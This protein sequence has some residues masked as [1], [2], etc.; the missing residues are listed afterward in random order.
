MKGAPMNSDTL[1]I[2]ENTVGTVSNHQVGVSNI[3]ARDLA[4]ETGVV[5]SRISANV[6]IRNPASK[7]ERSQKVFQGSVLTLGGD[8]WLVTRVDEGRAS[9]GSIT[10]RPTTRDPGQQ[11]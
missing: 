7:E 2:T 11:P 10:V 6:A 1:T 3:W 5:A 9:P 4:D 8:R